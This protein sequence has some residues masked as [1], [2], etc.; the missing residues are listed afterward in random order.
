MHFQYFFPGR[1]KI[2]RDELHE[3]GLGYVFDVETTATNG[4]NLAPRQVSNGPG[5]QH[6]LIV[7]LSSDFCGYHKEQQVWQQEIDCDY[8]V[9]MFTGDKRPTPETLQRDNLIE[10]GTLR[11]DDGHV[12]MFPAARH[13]EEFDGEIIPR[14]MLP[15]RLSRDP[16]G[17]W[18]PG[19][20]K[21]RYRELWRLATELLLALSEGEVYFPEI[22]NLVIECFKCNYRVSA[23]ELDLLGVHDDQVRVRVPRILLDL[24]N[25]D[26]LFKKKLTTLGIG[27]STS[28]QPAL[29]PDEATAAT[30]QPAAT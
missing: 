12:W 19:E 9:G 8:W 20:V 5:G 4:P 7:S 11:L 2:T 26:V 13:Y 23:A 25:F 16:T 14:R 15:T 27:N 28:G 1:T 22:D 6:G 21:E 18:V 17:L 24:D 10:G 29:V 3:L 30:D